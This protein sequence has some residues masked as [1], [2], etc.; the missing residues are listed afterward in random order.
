MPVLNNSAPRTYKPGLWCIALLA[1]AA[2][3]PAAA[4]PYTCEYGRQFNVSYSDDEAGRPQAT[5]HLPSGD[6]LLPG[7]PAASGARY[8]DGNQQWHT[9]GENALLEDGSGSQIRCRQGLHAATVAPATQQ[10]QPAPAT[11]A[12]ASSFVE[13]HGNVS[14]RAR[15]ALPPQALLTIRIQSG[16]RTLSEQRYELNGAQ[17]PIPFEA[18][19]DRDLMTPRAPL[20]VNG[21]IDVQGKRRCAGRSTLAHPGKGGLPVF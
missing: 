13:L 11:P 14:Y 12:A 21:Q 19:L 3:E 16:R 5:L 8:R 9:R 6:R 10:S 20:V 4:Q 2:A 18:T 1:T 17:V 15:I 7:V